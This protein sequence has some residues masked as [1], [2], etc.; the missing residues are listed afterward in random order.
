VVMRGHEPDYRG[1]GLDSVGNAA[2]GWGG[3][4]GAFWKRAAGDAMVAATAPVSCHHS[5][6][7][8]AGALCDVVDIE[9][10]STRSGVGGML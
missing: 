8:L 7:L 6:M 10:S 4:T 9:V 2:K 3:V 1:G 5:V